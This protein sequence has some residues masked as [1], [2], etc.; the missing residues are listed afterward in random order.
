MAGATELMLQINNDRMLVFY[1]KDT[2][3]FDCSPLSSIQLKE[4]EKGNHN[5]K[6]KKIGQDSNNFRFYSY[7]EID[8]EDL[9]RFFVRECVDDKEIRK[10]LFYI[11]RR[12][13][14]VEPFV[15]ALHELNLY[16]DYVM[17]CGNV[18]DDMFR[19]WAEKNGLD[20]SKKTSDSNEPDEQ[21]EK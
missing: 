9:M 6:L 13:E 18:Y 12:D 4:F 20:F 7:E 21:E 2:N 11:L 16:D 5:L 19:E 14:F 15:E 17:A 8:H 1:H 10:K 3:S